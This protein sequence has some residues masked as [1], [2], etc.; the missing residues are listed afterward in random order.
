M[1]VW[2]EHASIGKKV[3]GLGGKY[4]RLLTARP[5]QLDCGCRWGENGRLVGKE[6]SG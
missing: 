3:L 1:V 4:W 6:D 2:C 5:K